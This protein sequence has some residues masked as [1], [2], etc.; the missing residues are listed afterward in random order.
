[1]SVKTIKPTIDVEEYFRKM[2]PE[3]SAA[4]A[5]MCISKLDSKV[6][7]LDE[8]YAQ[9]AKT[10]GFEMGIC[11]ITCIVQVSAEPLPHPVVSMLGTDEGINKGLSMLKNKEF[12]HEEFE[13]D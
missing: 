10:Y 11:G 3:D 8:L 12:K 13:N 2:K 5:M 7:E 9:L 1:M 4:I 6:K